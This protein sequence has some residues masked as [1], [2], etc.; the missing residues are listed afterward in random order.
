M[1]LSIPRACGSW[2]K[3]PPVSTTLHKPISFYSSIPSS[4]PLKPQVPLF[5]RPPIHS[6][7]LSDLQKWHHWAKTLPVPHSDDPPDPTLLRRELKWL[8]EDALEV[9][10]SVPQ[11]GSHSDDRPI[12]LRTSLEQLYSVWRQRIEERRP[13]QYVVGCEHWRDLV[14][15]VQDGVLIPRPETEVFVDLV[16]DVVT[17]NGDLTQG[18]WADLGT[19]SG[20]IAIG[21][22]RILGPRGRVIATDL[23]PVAVSVAS[24][25]V[26][27]YSLQ[28]AVVFL[29]GLRKGKLT[30]LTGLIEGKP[31]KVCFWLYGKALLGS[32]FHPWV[33]GSASG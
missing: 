21:I 7:T 2:S 12:K 25:N 9:H 27:R 6:A 4:S 14:L 22:G 29:D 17:Q 16:G 24:F 26:Q 5:L 23:S 19:G 28:K 11:M 31:G 32:Q 1:K 20:A 10:S 33:F 30:Y 8:L 18:L 3:S 15:S 13:F